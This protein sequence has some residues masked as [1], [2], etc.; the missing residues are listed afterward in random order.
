MNKIDFPTSELPQ[1]D[2]N[3]S[4]HTL[5]PIDKTCELRPFLGPSAKYSDVLV[6]ETVPYEIEASDHIN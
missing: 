5:V 1:M 4:N 6:G 2:E 3:R